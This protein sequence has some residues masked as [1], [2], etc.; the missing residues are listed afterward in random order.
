MKILGY[1][2]LVQSV[3]LANPLLNYI[4]FDK[5]SDGENLA[6]NNSL[7]KMLLFSPG[8][9]GQNQHQKNQMNSLLP[10]LLYKEGITIF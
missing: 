7:L 4:L 8:L 3:V 10:F 5:F 2:C 9:L 6:E 1:F